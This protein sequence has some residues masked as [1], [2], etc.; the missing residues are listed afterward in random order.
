MGTVGTCVAMPMLNT[1]L[2]TV[3]CISVMSSGRHQGLKGSLRQSQ[4]QLWPLVLFVSPLCPLP[5]LPPLLLAQALTLT[6]P[7]HELPHGMNPANR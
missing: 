6:R 4:V 1:A 3:S 5:R 2:H 7:C